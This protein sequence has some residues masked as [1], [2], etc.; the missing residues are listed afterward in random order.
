MNKTDRAKE[1][2][3][4]IQLIKKLT[5]KWI[6]IHKVYQKE[7][8]MHRLNFFLQFVEHFKEKDVLELGC[9]AGVYG[10]VISK[11]AKSYV[12]VDRGEDYISQAKITRKQMDNPNVNFYNYSVKQFIKLANSGGMPTFNALF[13]SFVLYHLSKK[14]T[15]RLMKYV[16]PKC[17]V[18]IIQTRTKKRTPFRNYNPHKFNKPKNVEKWLTEAGFTCKTKW[19]DDKRYADTVALRKKDAED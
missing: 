6:K 4:V 16:L 5:P 7:S 1:T 10:Y 18:V 11:R 17:D 14:E 2:K 13:A 15:D 3:E 8:R 12:G 9:N 19:A